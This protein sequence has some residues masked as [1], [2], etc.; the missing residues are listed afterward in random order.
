MKQYRIEYK[1]IYSGNI[2]HGDWFDS[3]EFI[4]NNVYHL[5]KEHHG[6]INHWIGEK[7]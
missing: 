3:K 2:G 7:K 6:I 4:K 1:F 5:N